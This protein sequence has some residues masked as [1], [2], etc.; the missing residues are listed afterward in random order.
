MAYNMERAIYKSSAQSSVANGRPAY[1]IK[2]DAL[3]KLLSAIR[4]LFQS[5]S[6]PLIS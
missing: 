4:E 2:S 1:V 6:L 3:K 5:R